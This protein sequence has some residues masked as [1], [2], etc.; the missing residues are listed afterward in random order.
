MVEG[1]VQEVMPKLIIATMIHAQSMAIGLLGVIGVH[2][3]Q[4][5]VEERDTGT[6]HAQAHLPKME[7]DHVLDKLV[8]QDPV[9]CRCVQLMVTGQ[10]GVHGLHA[11][12]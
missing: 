4:H 10:N 9:A 7:G 6:G 2:A 11:K 5:V 12:I 1:F 3:Q 8:R